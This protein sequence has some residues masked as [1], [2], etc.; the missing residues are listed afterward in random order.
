M[1]FQKK[2]LCHEVRQY[3]DK[4]KQSQ[5]KSLKV[6]KKSLTA[7]AV[8]GFLLKMAVQL[9]SGRLIPAQRY[10]KLLN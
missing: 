1:F 2:F 8:M 10:E 6:F 7:W 9:G 3:F 5:T 4:V